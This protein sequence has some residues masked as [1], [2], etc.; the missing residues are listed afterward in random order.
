VQL[1]TMLLFELA[2]ERCAVPAEVVRE[3][4][5]LAALTPVPT[6]PPSV[7]G[8]VQVRGQI[9]PVLDLGQPPRGM[10]RPGAPLIVVELDGDR[11][12][13]LL[14]DRVLDGDESGRPTRE[15]DLARALDE[16]RRQS[17]GA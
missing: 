17:G 14:A 5:A 3:I 12:A 9:F 2:G 6:A 7:C 16:V 1:A 11:R 15:L 10:P 13:A 4:V 8:V